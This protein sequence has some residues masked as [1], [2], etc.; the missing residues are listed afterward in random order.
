MENA[1]TIKEAQIKFYG[2]SEE[3]EITSGL[4]GNL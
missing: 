4:G 2:I 1:Y 3:E